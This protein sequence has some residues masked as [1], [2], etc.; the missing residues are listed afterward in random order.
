MIQNRWADK[1]YLKNVQYRGPENLNARGKLHDLFN[2]TSIPWFSWVYK[3]MALQEGYRVLEVG[4]GPGNLWNHNLAY[5][6]QNAEF[7]LTD[8]SIGMLKTSQSL[9][10]DSRFQFTCMDADNLGFPDATFDL[11]LANYMLYHV[12]DLSGT[13]QGIRRVLKP[14]GR[15]IAATNGF[16]HMIEVYDLIHKFQPQFDK[17][18]YFLEFNLQN[19]KEILSRYFSTVKQ[20]QFECHLK[21]TEAEPLVD[22][23]FSMPTLDEM[24][25]GIDPLALTR[26]L[27][28][29]IAKTGS[30]KIQKE[31][32]LFIAS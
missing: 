1:E 21:I 13:L 24:K 15:L 18:T 32:G 4:C 25:H 2:V 8:L 29:E 9:L 23:I 20:K 7:L 11:V 28:S 14:G 31:Q 10:D 3:E 17:I 27:E 6:P 12:A 19:G 5:L 30:L 22:Y 16:R 26:F